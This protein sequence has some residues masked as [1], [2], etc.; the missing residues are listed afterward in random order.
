[1]AMRAMPADRATAATLLDELV[2]ARRAI[3]VTMFVLAALPPALAAIPAGLSAA[4]AADPN[5]VQ[6]A[7]RLLDYMA[8]D[9]GGAVSDGKV[10][11]ASEYSEMTEFAA[12][13]SAR[14]A[15]LPPTAA[16]AKLLDDLV[17]AKLVAAHWRSFNPRVELA[18]LR[19]QYTPTLLP[20][21]A[22]YFIF[23]VYCYL[24]HT[25]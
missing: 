14:L 3:G 22:W 12:S 9:Y 1:M 11:S 24:P 20:A 19:P 25:G 21:A 10:K 16:R 5:D 23:I 6:T 18:Q 13:V 4:P 2:T 17:F 7:W 15:A 8:V